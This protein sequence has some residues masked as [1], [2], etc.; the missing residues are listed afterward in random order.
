MIMKTDNRMKKIDLETAVG[1]FLLIGIFSL[2]YISVKLGRL[3]VLGNKGYEVYAEFEQVG[4]I[5]TGASVEI[6]GIAIGKVN[7]MR[8]KDYQALLSMEIDKGIKLQEDS[9]A[10]VRTK[11]LIGEKYILITPGGS[12]KIIPDGGKIRETESAIDTESLM[13]KYIFGKI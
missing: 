8:L 9:I 13:S 3:E 2:A 5:K 7:G 12:E 4:G 11:G 6:A 10:S 1:F